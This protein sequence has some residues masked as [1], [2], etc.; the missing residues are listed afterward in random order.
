MYR[1]R[2]RDY[3]LRESEVRTLTDV[4]KF[5]VVPT[6]DLVRFGCNGDRSQMESEL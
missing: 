4:G 5:R 6:D 2:N 1:G 3:S